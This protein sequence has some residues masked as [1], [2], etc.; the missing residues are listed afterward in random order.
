MSPRAALLIGVLASATV[1][2]GI[3]FFLVFGFAPDAA[4]TRLFVDLG[5]LALLAGVVFA[6]T[7]GPAERARAL[8]EALRELTRGIRHRRL[9]PESFGELADVARAFNEV[10]AFL[11]EHDDPNLGPIKSRPR[12]L[13]MRRADDEGVEH[14]THPELGPVRVIP[15]ERA[16]EPSDEKRANEAL[17]LIEEAPA[18][19]DEPAPERPDAAPAEARERDT[20][21]DEPKGEEGTVEESAAASTPPSAAAEREPGDAK[22]AFPDEQDLRALFDAF[23]DAKRSQDE[24]T[25]DLDFE[26]FAETLVDERARLTREHGCKTVRF[27]VTVQDGEV[28]L[29]PRLIR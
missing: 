4:R 1:A 29:L 7:R 26:A 23:V 24:P 8:A 27:E 19:G 25:E 21:I 2:A 28:S 20:A 18:E 14:S 5:L 22:P 12:R 13:K 15:K 6:F 17:R 10:A 16:E 9:T 3:G 11:S